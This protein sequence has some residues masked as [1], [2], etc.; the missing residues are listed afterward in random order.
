MIMAHMAAGQWIHVALV[1]DS[2]G[3]N[4]YLNGT[5]IV[6]TRP[7]ALQSD[8]VELGTRGS[9]WFDGRLDEV[10]IYDRAL[11]GEEIA[12]LASGGSTDLQRSERSAGQSGDP[13]IDIHSGTPARLLGPILGHNDNYVETPEISTPRE[14][15]S[16]AES[17]QLPPFV[18]A[19]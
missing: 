6:S 17:D 4:A 14:A 19:S 1:V 3:V 13:S 8:F 5:L 9:N 18:S 12:T 15:R 10:H 2:V 11:T 16:I 7:F